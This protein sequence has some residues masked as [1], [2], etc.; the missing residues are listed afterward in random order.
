MINELDELLA[1]LF[2][3]VYSGFHFLFRGFLDFHGTVPDVFSGM[4]D[5]MLC[6]FVYLSRFAGDCDGYLFWRLL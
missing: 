6:N 2:N 3:C 1:A 5:G 4:D